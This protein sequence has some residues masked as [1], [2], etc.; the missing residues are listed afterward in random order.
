MART[1]KGLSS[2]VAAAVGV[3][4][5]VTGGTS[6]FGNGAVRRGSCSTSALLPIGSVV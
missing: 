3:L 6:P 1:T 5:I 2:G 4:R